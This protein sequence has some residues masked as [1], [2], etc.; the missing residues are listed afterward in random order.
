MGDALATLLRDID[1]GGDRMVGN[2]DAALRLIEDIARRRPCVSTGLPCL[3]RA[4]GGGLY[5]GRS[6]AVEAMDKRGKTT[7]AGTISYNLNLAGVRH[8]YVAMEMGAAEIELRQAARHLGIPA[9]RFLADGRALIPALTAYANALPGNV[10]YLDLPGGTFRDLRSELAR[11]LS[12]HRIEGYILDY[13]QLVGGRDRA[14][15][16]EE[17]LRGVAQ[18]CADFGRKHGLWSLILAQLNEDGMGFGSRRG[19]QMSADQVYILHR[20]PYADTAWLEQRVSRYTPTGDVG[21]AG[22][23]ALG[24]DNRGPYFYDLDDVAA[25]AQRALHYLSG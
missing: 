18:W 25:A 6:Y 11:A 10:A 19:L 16:L 24:L 3:D 21:S 2:R 4:M 20:E 15:S 8:A 17:H 13:W 22:N 9:T 5:A 12:R 14:Q 7:L 1:A 23:H